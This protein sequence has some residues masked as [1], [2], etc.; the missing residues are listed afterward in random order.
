MRSSKRL[1]LGTAYRFPLRKRPLTRD[2]GP[3]LSLLVL[4]L[5][6][7]DFRSAEQWWWS[8]VPRRC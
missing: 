8:H 5:Q 7:R 2:L 4:L 1:E 3:F 6:I